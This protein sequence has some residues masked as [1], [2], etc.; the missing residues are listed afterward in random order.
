MASYYNGE[1]VLQN[2]QRPSHLNISCSC[3]AAALQLALLKV[4]RYLIGLEKAGLFILDL[5]NAGVGFH[6]FAVRADAGA[7]AWGFAMALR[8]SG[9][10]LRVMLSHCTDSVAVARNDARVKRL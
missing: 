1:I 10:W 9:I 7:R 6:A 5:R 8:R 4:R 2:E 3:F